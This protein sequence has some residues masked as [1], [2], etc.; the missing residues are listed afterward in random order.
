MCV[1]IINIIS[2]FVLFCVFFPAKNACC[3][4]YKRLAMLNVIW[5]NAIIETDFVF[6]RRNEIK[7]CKFIVTFWIE[8]NEVCKNLLV[9]KNQVQKNRIACLPCSRWNLLQFKRNIILVFLQFFLLSSQKTFCAHNFQCGRRVMGK[10]THTQKSH[11]FQ[12]NKLLLNETV[13]FIKFL[14]LLYNG[15]QMC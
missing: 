9:V 14:R 13:E 1:I 12:W 10:H 11:I 6:Y 15:P 8:G 2:C 3:D 5:R 7:G 4:R